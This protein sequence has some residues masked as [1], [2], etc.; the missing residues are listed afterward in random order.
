MAKDDFVRIVYPKTVEGRKKRTSISVDP[1]LYHVFTLIR[2][3]VPAA[4]AQLRSWAVDVE[5]QRTDELARIGASRLVGRRI[6]AEIRT[7]VE[8][9]LKATHP[10]EPKEALSR[11]VKQA[12]PRDRNA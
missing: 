4:R 12:R 1:D 5:I 3:S 10:H 11:A 8:R 7:L 9:G 6:M 2:G